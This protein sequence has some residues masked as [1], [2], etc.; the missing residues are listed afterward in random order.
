MTILAATDGASRGNPGESG[1]GI[2][3][4]D[5][6]GA[7]LV[8]VGKFIGLAT[9]N[10]AEY[11]AL[12]TCLGYVASLPCE[13]VIVQSDSELMVRQVNG[14]YK[15]KDTMLKRFFQQVQARLTALPFP[16][17][18]RHVTREQNRHADELANRAINLRRDVTDLE[19]PFRS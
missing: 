16:V 15:V 12:L 13:R 5:E 17:E 4:T 10:V 11:Q 19:S 7:V 9:N 2:H 8:S 1:I 18:I 14:Q 6:K 3:I